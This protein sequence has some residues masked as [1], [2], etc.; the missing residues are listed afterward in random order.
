M[1]AAAIADWMMLDRFVFR[2]DD[3]PSFRDDEAAPCARGTTSQGDSF[4]VAFRIVDPPCVSR[5]CLQWPGGPKEA[6]SCDLVATHRSLLL[7]R[8]TSSPVEKDGYLVHPQ[9]YFLCEGRPPSSPDQPPLQLHRIPICTIPLVFNLEDGRARTAQRPFDLHTIGI[10]SCGEEFAVA[11]LCVTKPHRPGRV[12]AELCVLRSHVTSSDHCWEVEQHLPIMYD[13]VESSELERW[14]TDIVVPFEKLLCW[15]NYSLGAIL[16]C[17]ILEERPV[18]KYLPLSI[19]CQ[20]GDLERGRME[21]D[22]VFA[23]TS[24]QLWA[25]GDFPHEALIFPVAN[26]VK[27]NV[28]Y[29]LLAEEAKCG[30]DKAYVVAFD[31]NTNEVSVLPYITEDLEDK[32]A[33][34]VQ[35]K[36]YLLDPFIPSELPRFLGYV[37]SEHRMSQ[38]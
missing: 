8:L 15:F 13:R 31:T 21:W 16:F 22:K 28:L 23:I 5:L 30:I 29:F 14:R 34:F 6:S 11:Q 25:L 7:L 24:D 2:R 18:I 36:S 4:R 12:A 35:R 17:K 9:D 10:L 3:D 26:M 32:D 27:P 33:D 1:A 37:S 19:R 20:P 38:H